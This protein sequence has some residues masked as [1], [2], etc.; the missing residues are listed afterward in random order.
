MVIYNNIVNNL[1]KCPDCLV[2]GQATLILNK[3]HTKV[4]NNYRPITTCLLIA[5]KMLFRIMP[6]VMQYHLQMSDLIPEEQKGGESQKQ[7]RLVVN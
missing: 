4:P 7:G 3:A 1:E 6:K 5:C 2:T